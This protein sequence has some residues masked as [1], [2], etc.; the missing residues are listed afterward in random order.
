MWN[1]SNFFILFPSFRASRWTSFVPVFGFVLTSRYGFQI[2]CTKGKCREYAK[3]FWIK[4]GDWKNLTDF[5]F[6]AVLKSQ[7]GYTTASMSNRTVTATNPFFEVFLLSETHRTKIQV[8]L[9]KDLETAK[10]F[11]KEFASVVERKYT[12]YSPQISSSSRRRR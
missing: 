11:A 5:P 4:K 8:A 9:F 10:S 12:A 1:P 2:D 6:V 7:K 3:A